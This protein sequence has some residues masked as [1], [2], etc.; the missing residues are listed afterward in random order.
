M[1]N[2]KQELVRRYVLTGFKGMAMGAADVVP[3][4]SGG[5]IAFITGIYDELLGSI[6]QLNL[7]ALKIIKKEGVKAFWKHINGTFLSVL[8]LGIA[9]SIVSLA[10]LIEY[11]MENHAIGL[12]SFFF[13]L[14]GASIIYVGKQVNV[15]NVQ[16]IV[17]F[18]IGA[19]AAYFITVLPPMK[20][21]S[22]MWFIFASGLIAICAMILPGISGSFILLILGAYPT[23]I[24]AISSKNL[25]IIGVFAIGCV[26]GLLSFSRVLKYLLDHFNAVTIAVLTGFLL[27]SLNK[28]WPWKITLESYVKHA[29]TPKEKI[30]P[31][32]QENVLPQHFDTPPHLFMAIAMILIGFG[33]IF[34]LEYVATKLQK[35]N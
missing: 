20:E 25:P 32:V 34:G 23:I 27:G 35:K 12:W 8:F 6:N 30:I 11:L 17:G 26:I 9:I 4:V 10:K 5:T 28:L 15:W 29:G 7:K 21:T 2:N 31:L 24:E 22:D 14:V 18:V 19:L 16:T 1:T 13:G 33:L 3:G